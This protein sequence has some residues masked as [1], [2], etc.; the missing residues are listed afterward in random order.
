MGNFIKQCP[1]C[2]KDQNYTIKHN[3]MKAIK[4]NRLCRDC[5]GKNHSKRMTGSGNPSYGNKPS[6]DSIA[7]GRA[8]YVARGVNIYTPELREIRRK[9][10]SGTGNSM[11]GRSF[12][13]SWVEKY[14]TEVADQKLIEF[15]SK[16][17][18]ATSGPNNP[19]YGKPSPNGSGNGWK[20]WFQDHF[21]R[22]LLE[23]SFLLLLEN[24]NIDWTSGEIIRIPY[25]DFNGHKRTYSPDFITSTEVIEC[26]PESL[27]KSMSVK[28]KARAGVIWARGQGLNYIMV[29][30]GRPS[31]D[32][33]NKL[34]DEGSIIWT[35]RYAKKFE[36]YKISH[37][38]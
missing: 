6:P 7:K 20:G 32:V 25:T 34:V 4:V 38:S 29:D 9:Q 12:Y 8:T 33:I 31:F 18:K 19:M 11:Y 14:G 22:S 30:P 37:S 26:K 35:P 3:L 36:D 13:D 5:N 21:F 28:I 1:G 2:G 24:K 15:K 27:Q 10:M 16:I 23:L 17:S